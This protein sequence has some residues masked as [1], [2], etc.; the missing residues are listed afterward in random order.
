MGTE[1]I[2]NEGHVHRRVCVD[3][4]GVDTRVLGGDARDFDRSS[5]DADALVTSYFQTRRRQQCRVA[6]PHDHEVSYR[7]NDCYQ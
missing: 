1:D 7:S 4:A 6:P 2:Q 3:F 5:D